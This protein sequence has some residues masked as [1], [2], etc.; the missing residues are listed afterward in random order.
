[1]KCGGE[2]SGS[3]VVVAL[4]GVKSYVPL[5]DAAP[6]ARGDDV[7]T[8]GPVPC[9]PGRQSQRSWVPPVA[10]AASVAVAAL[11]VVVSRL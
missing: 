6:M 1:M 7:V 3:P 5:A 10:A 2:S 4:Y 9:V 8:M 11:A